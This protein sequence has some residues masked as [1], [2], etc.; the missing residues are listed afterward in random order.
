[1]HHVFWNVLEPL[2]DGARPVAEYGGTYFNHRPE[3]SMKT[4][5]YA[6]QEATY[7]FFRYIPAL[8]WVAL[9]AY[10]AV[11]GSLSRDEPAQMADLALVPRVQASESAEV[12][13]VLQ[14]SVVVRDAAVTSHEVLDPVGAGLNT[15][16]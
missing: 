13:A 2:R 4:A 12:S 11:A 8:G 7:S 1:M 6:E 5:R 16:R 14:N 15:T 9:L 10:F 3:G